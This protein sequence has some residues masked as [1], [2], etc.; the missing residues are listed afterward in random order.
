MPPRQWQ[1]GAKCGH[2]PSG[3]SPCCVPAHICPNGLVTKG[4]CKCGNEQCGFS[5]CEHLVDKRQCRRE[6][7]V[8]RATGICKHKRQIQACDQCRLTPRPRC[9]KHGSLK[10]AGRQCRGCLKEARAAAKEEICEP[11]EGE[12]PLKAPVARVPTGRK[13]LSSFVFAEFLLSRAS[14]ELS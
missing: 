1:V 14:P 11:C 12:S 5:L 10:R 9:P 7:C 8:A 3:R 2:G 6:P 13:V 4:I